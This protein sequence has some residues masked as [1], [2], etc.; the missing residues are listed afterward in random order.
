MNVRVVK[1]TVKAQPGI[2][3]AIIALVL[4]NVCVYAYAALY[5]K[6][7]FESLQGK[8]F[9]KRKLV[10]GAASSD[11]GAVYQQGESDLKVWRERI[12]PKRDFARFVGSLF[13]TASK[14]SLA[15]KGMTY[16]VDQLKDENLV[17]YTLDFDVSGK[18]GGIKSFIADIGKMREIVT[19]DNIALTNKDEKGGDAVALKV[20]LTVYLRAEGQ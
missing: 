16:K 9:E 14:N 4:L 2:F 10:S 19:I 1:E 7:R 11:L 15:F 12:I 18:Y 8:W 20:Q 13:E 17:S 6:P 3:A 5:Q